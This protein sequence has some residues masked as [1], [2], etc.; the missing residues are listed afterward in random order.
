MGKVLEKKSPETSKWPKIIYPMAN[1]GQF[2]EEQQ[3]NQRFWH[4][5]RPVMKKENVSSLS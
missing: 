1:E 2:D 3:V 4:T 5:F